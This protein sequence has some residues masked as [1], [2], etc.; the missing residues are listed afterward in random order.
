MARRLILD[1]TALIA[2]ERDGDVPGI[3]ESDQLAIASISLGEIYRGVVAAHR[4]DLL[5]RRMAFF[6]FLAAGDSIELLTYGVGTTRMHGELLDFTKKS[7]KPRGYHD[8]I[9]ASH[10][11]E[12]GREILSA[13]QKARFQDLPG[14]AVV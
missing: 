11:R 4:P 10:A 8:L 6:E 12:T 13:D 2:L 14:V 5:A 9:I 3:R 7:G 1:T